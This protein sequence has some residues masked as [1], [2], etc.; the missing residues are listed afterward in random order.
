MQYFVSHLSKDAI[1]H[2]NFVLLAD[3]PQRPY[4]LPA[5]IDFV[6]GN[7]QQTKDLLAINAEKAAQ[8]MIMMESDADAI[9]TAMTVQSINEKA[10][11]T[12]NI[13][14]EENIKLFKRIGINDIVC[15]EVVAGSDILE[16]YN[17][18]NGCA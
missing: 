12:V 18:C 11:I 1:A 4:G 8:A 6:H 17:K 14:E 16:S 9:M 3:L 10:K 2:Q 15:D 7:P 13:Q 5:D